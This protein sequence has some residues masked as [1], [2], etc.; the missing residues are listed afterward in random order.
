[1]ILGQT[2]QFVEIPKIN[3][4]IEQYW[5]CEPNECLNTDDNIVSI[6]SS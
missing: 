2:D 3:V 5:V 4:L 6:K 1:M